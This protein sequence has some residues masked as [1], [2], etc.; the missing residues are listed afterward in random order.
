MENW[1]G[2][3]AKTPIPDTKNQ[4]IKKRGFGGR[5]LRGQ[6]GSGTRR[7]LGDAPPYR[8]CVRASRGLY[9][10]LEIARGMKRCIESTVR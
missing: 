8:I 2:L 6:R 9:G 7:E 5:F 1:V 3:I 4:P 10:D